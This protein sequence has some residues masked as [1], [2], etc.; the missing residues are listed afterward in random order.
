MPRGRPPKYKSALAYFNVE[1]ILKRKGYDVKITRG[2][3]RKTIENP[4]ELQM[5]KRKSKGGRK[6]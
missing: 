4:G 6:C 3:V 2:K 1:N 5:A